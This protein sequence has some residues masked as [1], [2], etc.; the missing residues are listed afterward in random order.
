M[1][2]YLE[3][4]CGGMYSG[5]S[6]ELIRR[7]NRAKYARKQ[8]QLFKPA[9]DGRYHATQVVAHDNR[10]HAAQAVA[11]ALAILPLVEESTDVVAIDE[12]QFLA[13]DETIKVV[14]EL[15]CRGKKVI[16]AGLDLDFAGRPFGAIP[17]LLAIA[18]EID[19]LRA[20]CIKCGN[21]A[22]ISQRLVNGEPASLRDPQILVGGVEAYEA[23]CRGCWEVKD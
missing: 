20:I 7:V 2:G 15:M 14:H 11:T 19:K 9:L 1:K 16:V 6:S 3:V 22:Y 10:N 23:R 4:I 8:V 21:K 5:K 17:H 13:A 18:D 12:L